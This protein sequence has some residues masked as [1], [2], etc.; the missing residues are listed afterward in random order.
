MMHFLRQEMPSQSAIVLLCLHVG[1]RKIKFRSLCIDC[2]LQEEEISQPLTLQQVRPE[3]IK[4][5]S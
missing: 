5:Q 2:S 1:L 3:E 4:D